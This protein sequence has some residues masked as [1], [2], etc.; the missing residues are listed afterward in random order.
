MPND[1]LSLVRFLDQPKAIDHFKTSPRGC[2]RKRRCAVG[3]TVRRRET[4]R[5]PFCKRRASGYPTAAQNR[6][7]ISMRLSRRE[8]SACSLSVFGEGWGGAIIMGRH[9]IVPAA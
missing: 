4:A 3:E 9:A 6:H 1:G 2:R 5:S 8:R 7:T